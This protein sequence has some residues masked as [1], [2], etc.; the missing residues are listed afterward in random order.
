[1]T[2]EEIAAE[3]QRRCDQLA[4]SMLPVLD[5]M[6]QILASEMREQAGMVDHTLKDLAKLG[7][8]YR[9]HNYFGV[10]E[11]LKRSV[12]TWHSKGLFRRGIPRTA[13]QAREIFAVGHDIK[14]VHVQSTRLFDHIYTYVHRMGNLV[15]AVA[16]IDPVE[17]PYLP[18]VIKG[19]RYMIPRD[20]I[21]RSAVIV[22][23]RLHAI[24]R[25]SMPS[26]ARAVG[27]Q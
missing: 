9:R 4:E 2:A 25:Q 6:T 22:R 11:H 20:F 23:P 5:D 10:P 13:R 24:I 15:L 17:V 18:Y 8:P 16:G 12:R 1:M 26:L 14:L 3:L 7:H 19:T 27:A 21:G